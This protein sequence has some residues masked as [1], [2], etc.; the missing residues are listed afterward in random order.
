M[1]AG[2]SAVVIAVAV[3][4]AVAVVPVVAVGAD[5]TTDEVTVIFFLPWLFLGW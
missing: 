1:N 4:V 5:V 2:A 3:S